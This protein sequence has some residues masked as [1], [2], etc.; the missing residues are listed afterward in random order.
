M[1]C[2]QSARLLVDLWFSRSLLQFISYQLFE[3]LEILTI[4]EFFSQA[5]SMVVVKELT[6][7][8]SDLMLVRIEVL[9]DMM[10][11]IKS[12][13]NTF[14]SALPLAIVC[15]LLWIYRSLNGV[16]MVRGAWSNDNLHSGWIVCLFNSS[17]LYLRNMRLM[18]ELELWLLFAYLIRTGL[19]GYNR[20]KERESVISISKSLWTEWCRYNGF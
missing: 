5:L 7:F 3:C 10:L 12:L 20:P 11:L 15:F 2:F 4:F 9:I 19:V 17:D 16:E 14:P 8:S 13:M 6:V 18:T 1:N